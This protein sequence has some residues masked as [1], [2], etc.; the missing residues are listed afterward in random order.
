MQERRAIRRRHLMFHLRVFDASTGE[1][2]GNLVDITPEGLMVTGEEG[3][4]PGERCHLRMHLP[5]EVFDQATLE[6]SATVVWCSDDMSPGLYDTGFKDLEMPAHQR[7]R[8][9][10]LIDEYDLRDTA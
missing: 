6:F 7:E 3:C 1:P 4:T 2:L 8:L 9:E 10:A 5:V